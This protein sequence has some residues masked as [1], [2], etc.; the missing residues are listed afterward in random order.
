MESINGVILWAKRSEIA[1][2]RK[3]K[4]ATTP[5]TNTDGRAL[6]TADAPDI[7]MTLPRVG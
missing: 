4:L 1:R 5:V 2:S 6:E 3:V 7:A